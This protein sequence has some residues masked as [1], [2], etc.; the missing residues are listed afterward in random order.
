MRN[1]TVPFATSC[2]VG[3]EIDPRYHTLHPKPEAQKSQYEYLRPD[4]GTAVYKFE[5]MG[6]L[7]RQIAMRAGRDPV[8]DPP[9][10]LS[11]RVNHASTRKPG[12]V[13]DL[14]FETR[15]LALGQRTDVCAG[16][17]AEN[18]HYT[19]RWDAGVAGGWF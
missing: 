1:N 16:P 13:V 10:V 15:E 7:V 19:F 3:G 17:L 2:G 5:E 12:D 9:L 11:E 14:F 6:N 18:L 4:L 8:Y